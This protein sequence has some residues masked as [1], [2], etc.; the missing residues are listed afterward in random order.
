MDS[1]VVVAIVD[2]DAALRESLVRLVKSAGYELSLLSPR[3]NTW[4]VW[5]CTNSAAR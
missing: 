5:G 4:Q 3:T 1:S 2:D